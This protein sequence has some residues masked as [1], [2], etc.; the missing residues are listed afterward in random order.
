MATSG[1]T[2]YTA[3]VSEIIAEAMEVIGVLELGE[4]V[5]TDENTSGIRSLNLLLKS[6]QADPLVR[7][8]F[9]EEKTVALSASTATYSLDSDTERVL[10]AWLVIDGTTV[11]LTRKTME[12]F[13]TAQR[14]ST[15]E[16]QPQEYAIN[17]APDTPTIT[18][19]PTPA[20]DY[21]L[22]YMAER[23][24]E[25]ISVNTETVD[26]PVKATDMIVKGMQSILASKYQLPL[27]ERAYFDGKYA[28]AQIL[29]K[30]G[31]SESNGSDIPMPV[32]LLI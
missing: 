23:T 13:D 25:D 9:K 12:Y 30:A 5:S 8:R 1:T 11:P 6:L 32:N 26:L 7:L 29:Y 22:Y 28:Q 15:A 18:V 16:N 4:S 31:D 21:T 17:Y 19:Y 2:T 14:N 24:I 27:Q 3:N 20:G 10:Y